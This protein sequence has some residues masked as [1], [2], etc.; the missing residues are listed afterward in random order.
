MDP[1]K[2]KRVTIKLRKIEIQPFA[3]MTRR[4]YGDSFMCPEEA[5][6]RDETVP[7]AVGTTLAIA[8]LCTVGGYAG[9]RYMKVKKV[10]YDT[11][12]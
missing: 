2:E 4:R 11:I 3:A 8:V 12:E 10:E 9:Y 1:K 6:R 5:G 7:L